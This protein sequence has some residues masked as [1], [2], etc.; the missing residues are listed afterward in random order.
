MQLA[1]RLT[2]LTAGFWSG[3]GHLNRC[4]DLPFGVVSRFLFPFICSPLV[5]PHIVPLVRYGPTSGS[6]VSG[7]LAPRY[8]RL[9][10]A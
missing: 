9:P 4:L 7:R 1:V 10:L 6:H 8:V 3:S 5:G 2:D